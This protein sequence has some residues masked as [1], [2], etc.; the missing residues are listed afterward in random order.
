MTAA[1]FRASYHTMRHVPSR[2]VVQIV[3]EVPSEQATA[4]LVVLGGAPGMGDARWFAVAALEPDRPLPAALPPAIRADDPAQAGNDKPGA[5]RQSWRSLSRCKQAAIR[6][7]DPEFQ[8]WIMA[9]NQDE[10]AKHVRENCFVA[11]RRELDT[12]ENAAAQ[13]DLLDERFRIQ[14]GHMT[15]PRG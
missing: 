4:A 6:C 5:T 11:S 12:D 13:W 2:G 3:L 7:A 14:T 1:A 8:A 15:E 9:S 10:A